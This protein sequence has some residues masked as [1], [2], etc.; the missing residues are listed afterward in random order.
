VF[1]ASS[2]LREG[3]QVSVSILQ[4]GSYLAGLKEY[5][6]DVWNF[7][8]VLSLTSFYIAFF[9]RYAGMEASWS[10]ANNSIWSTYSMT[11]SPIYTYSFFYSLSLFFCWIRT[12]RIFYLFEL[13]IVVGIA[14]QM[15]RDV[16]LWVVLYSIVLGAFCMLFMG[17][18]ELDTLIPGHVTCTNST[19]LAKDDLQN[20]SMECGFAYVLLRPMFQSFGEFNLN[21]MAN[22][23]N[24]FILIF[25]YLS[26]NLV[27]INLL[28]A[29]MSSTYSAIKEQAR[30]KRLI[31]TYEL[32][33][34]HTR[35]AVALP[36]PFNCLLLLIDLVLF[37]CQYE[38]LK[39][40]FPDYTWGQRLDRC[41][42]D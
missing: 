14:F 17:T 40:C 16:L 1:F 12:L 7:I 20:G 26:L 8:D 13:G 37:V 38:T 6:F 10:S 2:L 3:S 18:S 36:P 22:T 21:Q 29:M 25:M 31:F 28:I 34:E 33:Q 27:L 32:V 30:S 24:I 42:L 9:L 39:M 23:Y 5:L 41:R 19:N 35:R 4:R 15:I 11:D